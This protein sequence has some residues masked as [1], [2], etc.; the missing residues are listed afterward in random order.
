MIDK[1]LAIMD[2]FRYKKDIYLWLVIAAF[3]L[4]LPILND[5]G[6]SR[7]RLLISLVIIWGS[8]LC[9]SGFI[10]CERRFPKY[11]DTENAVLLIIKTHDPDDRKLV[12]KYFFT[13]LKKRFQKTHALEMTVHILPVYQTERFFEKEES[14]EIGLILNSNA[15]I[16]YWGE[17]KTAKY[18]SQPVYSIDLEML[19]T[20]DSLPSIYRNAL[21]IE[22]KKAMLSLQKVIIPLD[23]NLSAFNELS[24]ALGYAA[25]YILGYSLLITKHV[26]EGEAIFEELSS[27]IGNI[28][29]NIPTIAY[30]KNTVPLMLRAVYIVK[31]ER[32]YSQYRATKEK[33]Y[34]ENMND[35]IN[36]QEVLNNMVEAYYTQSALYEFCMNRDIKKAKRYI[37]VC[38]QKKFKGYA[39][40]FDRVF[41]NIYKNPTNTNMVNAYRNYRTI[42]KNNPDWSIDNSVEEFVTDLVAEEPDKIQMYWLASML[43]NGRGDYLL[44]MEYLDFFIQNSNISFNADMQKCITKLKECNSQEKSFI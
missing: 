43:A 31:A 3:G 21:Q 27:N 8:V 11:K 23:N 42:I 35:Y 24:T 10:Y 37:E 16:A 40:R 9:V 25:D 41:L 1:F 33:K 14:K 28:S 7:N 44:S 5:T 36:K 6:L 2:S 18:N 38:Y 15:R 26:D 12:E 30:L 19:V 32:C 39:W 22:M 17:G 34:L 20:H 13:E 29:K 4:S